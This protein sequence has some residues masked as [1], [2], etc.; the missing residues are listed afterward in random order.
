MDYYEYSILGYEET[1]PTYL[2]ALEFLRTHNK[3][4]DLNSVEGMRGHAQRFSAF[5]GSLM[6]H[7]LK[8][9]RQE[10]DKCQSTR[11][12]ALVC[13]HLPVHAQAADVRCL[14]WNSKE[15]LETLWLFEGTVIAYLAGHD[16]EG[17]FF[18]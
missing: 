12:Y 2:N 17:E 10:L 16:H 1:H 11:T 5:N 6:P 13:G 7:Q 4:S 8:W 3:N 9:L 18:L 15:V 14:A